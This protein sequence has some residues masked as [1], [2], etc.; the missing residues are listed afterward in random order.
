MAGR[1][2]DEAELEARR[3]QSRRAPLLVAAGM[4]ALTL[5]GLWIMRAPLAENVIGRALATRNVQMSYRIASIGLRTQR[6]ENIVLGNPRDP[7]LVA[8]WM[9]VDISFMG[10]S[11]GVAAVRAGGV[12]LKGS[13]T[14]GTLSLGEVDKFIGQGGTTETMLPDIDIALSDARAAIW[15]DYGPLGVDIA[16]KGNLRNSFAGHAALAMPVMRGEGCAAERLLANLDIAMR[17]GSPHVRGPVTARALGC[18]ALG[19]ALAGSRIDVNAQVDKQLKG[20]D[21]TA[22]FAAAALHASGMT[23]GNLAGTISLRADGKS[24]DGKGRIGGKSLSGVGMRAGGSDLSFSFKGAMPTGKPVEASMEG[25]LALR[26]VAA[27]GCDPLAGAASATA[28]TPFAPLVAKLARA[29]RDASGNNRFETRLALKSGGAGSEAN[30][31]D[32]HFASTSGARIDLPAGSRAAMHW[33]DGRW[34]VAGTLTMGGGGFP[35]GSLVLA[36]GARGGVSGTLD[37]QPYAAA[38]ARLAL[39]PVRFSA[40]PDGTSR[41]ATTA[42]MDG[43]L[44][45]GMVKGLTVPLAGALA[46]NGALALNGGCVPLHWQTLR[47]STLALDPTAL[48]LCPEEGRTMLRLAGGKVTGGARARNV[49]L[50]GRIGSSPLKLTATD[51]AFALSRSGFRANQLEAR[52]GKDEAP[53][54]LGATSLDGTLGG[55][56]V[57]GRFSGGH[58]RIGTVPLNLSEM[59]GSWRFAGGRLDVDGGLRVSDTQS[60][61]RFSPVVSRDVHL[62]LI[63]G[64]IAANG[65]LQHP[66]RGN[67]FARVE[68]AHDLSSGIG[69]AKFTLENLHFGSGLQPDDLTSLALGV[70]ANVNGSVTGDGQINWT[71]DKVTSTGRFSTEGMNLAAAFGPVEGL[72]TTLHFTDLLAM[73]TAPGQVATMKTVNPGVAVNDGRVRFQ[74]LRNSRARIEDGEWPFAGG[75]LTLLPSTMDFDVKGARHL[76]FRVTGLEAG[77]FINTLELNNLS[78]TGTYDGLFPMV[79]DASGG[80][81][82]GGILV[83]RQEGMPPLLVENAQRLT[84]PCDPMRQAGTLSYVGEVSNA[85]MG[86]YGKLAFDALKKLR[87]K[88][89]TILLDGAVDGEFVTRIAINGVNQGSD[90]SH[91]SAIMRNFLGLPFIFNVRIE[92]PFRGL[93]NTYQSFVDPSALVRG[94]LGPQYKTVLENKL[95]VQ[96]PESD[97]GPSREGE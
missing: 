75:R 30:L 82:V 57:D 71:P 58:G 31:T 16:G 54:I 28:G 53:V 94:S 96:P 9:E 56:G 18:P 22:R 26:D 80:R 67:P 24:F 66:A 29:V 89:L 46:G 97:K 27:H 83:A 39:A 33:P 42:T 92:A 34:S 85:E 23:L 14:D 11:P 55:S 8:R 93:L 35:Q 62:T 48:T 64:R 20:V 1:L 10:L 32:M 51:L 43:P 63:N 76:I 84:V 38:N 44:A 60:D 86:A 70:V 37:L 69:D 49:A 25:R 41:F 81:I 13:V 21:G 90:E 45:D 50:A 15:T 40:A 91:K 77:A 68:I 5:G 17:S 59:V 3:R 7:D 2:N 36:Q 52:I 4:F 47:V 87:Y 73:E 74:L 79:F 78:A 6:I 19:V 72:S 65:R 88:C 95:A 61:A 12:R